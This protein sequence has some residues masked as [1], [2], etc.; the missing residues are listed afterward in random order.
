MPSTEFPISG[1]KVYELPVIEFA[2]AEADILRENEVKEGLEPF[3][4]V[5]EDDGLARLHAFLPR[6]RR[7]CEAM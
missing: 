5:R 6:H 4:I 3:V 1:E 7:L 2:D